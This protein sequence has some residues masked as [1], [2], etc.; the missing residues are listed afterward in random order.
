MN[1]FLPPCGNQLAILFT[2]PW[3]KRPT[4]ING[5]EL[6]S[7]TAEL[8]SSLSLRTCPQRPQSQ[9][10]SRAVT[11][12]SYIFHH[13]SPPLNPDLLPTLLSTP[14]GLPPSLPR[15]LDPARAERTN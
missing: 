3:K 14:L 15:K 9:L 13:E 7:E 12:S 4:A 2:T 10:E 11:Q 6:G 1:L 8:T 5:T